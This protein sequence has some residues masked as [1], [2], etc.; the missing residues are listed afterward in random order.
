MFCFKLIIFIIIC[1]KFKN[2]I[3]FLNKIFLKYVSIIYNNIYIC[4]IYE[5]IFKF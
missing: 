1:L 4:F 2:Y 3:K 5:T